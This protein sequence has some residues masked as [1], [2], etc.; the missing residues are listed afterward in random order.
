MNFA[1]AKFYQNNLT[2]DSHTNPYI[3]RRVCL[4]VKMASET[5]TRPMAEMAEMG[6]QICVRV[7]Q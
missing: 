2:S 5:V 7:A 1:E 6:Y 4:P 3:S